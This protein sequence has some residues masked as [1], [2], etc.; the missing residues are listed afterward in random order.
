VS[1]TERRKGKEGELEVVRI[2]RDHGWPQAER[3]AR[4]V[5]QD[6]RGDIANGPLQAHLEVRRRERINI[7][8]CLEDAERGA[9]EGETP[10]LV[11]RRS[12]GRWYVALPLEELL[13]LLLAFEE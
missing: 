12:R 8:G 3:T 2:L 6:G 9:A 10:M 7:W 1:A 13:P 5:S 4:G 11:F